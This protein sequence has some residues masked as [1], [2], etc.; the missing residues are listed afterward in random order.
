LRHILLT[1]LQG[2]DLLVEAREMFGEVTA[3]VWNGGGFDPHGFWR[4][5]GARKL[6]PTGLATLRELYAFRDR[7]ARR[8]DRPPFKVI[9]DATLVRLSEARPRTHSELGRIKG[10]TPYLVR[11]YGRRV[12]QAI[13][14]GKRAGP[15]SLPRNQGHRRPAPEVTDRYEALRTWRKAR[16]AQRG[17]DPDVVVSNAALMAL[18]RRQPATLKDLEKMDIL[19][20][21]KQKKYGG[22]ILQVLRQGSSHRS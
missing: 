4:I 11:R 13:A 2:A 14:R 9:P 19:G 12:L 16:A 21:V 15:P 7:E 8:R 10:M 20:P 17:V 6:D 18:A 3:A 1:E 22:E 5:R